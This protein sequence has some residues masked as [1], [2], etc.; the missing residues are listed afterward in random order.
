VGQSG[1]GWTAHEQTM[2]PSEEGCV[3]KER[4]EEEDS[5]AAGRA[6]SFIQ[7]E[8][9]GWPVHTRCLKRRPLN[10]GGGRHYD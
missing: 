9:G 10:S 4:I 1:R 8:S 7:L 5:R 3:R 6:R 2:R